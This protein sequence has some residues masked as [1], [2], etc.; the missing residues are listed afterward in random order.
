MAKEGLVADLL[1]RALRGSPEELKL[2]LSLASLQLTPGMRPLK[3]GMGNKLIVNALAEACGDPVSELTD[4]LTRVGDLGVLAESRLAARPRGAEVLLTLADVHAALI[5]LSTQA[6]EGSTAR[7]TE[8]LAELLRSSSPVEARYM[9]R[10]LL[11]KLRTGLGGRSLRAALGQAGAATVADPSEEL[12]ACEEAVVIAKAA[13]EEAAVAARAAEASGEK[14]LVDKAGVGL[15]KAVRAVAAAEKKLVAMRGKRRRDAVQRVNDVFNVQPC[16]HQLVNDLARQTVWELSGGAVAGIPLTPMTAAP[17]ASLDEVMARMGEA[18]PFLAEIKY[19][20]ERCQLHLLPEP[21]QAAPPLAA[22]A[23]EG[24]GEVEVEGEAEAAGEGVGGRVVLYSRSLDDMSVRFPDVTD[25]LPAALHGAS[26]CVLDAE[27]C[28]YDPVAE[29]VLP[30]QT[31]SSRSRKAPTAEETAATPVCL[32]VFDL[33]ELDG[34]SLL[35]VPLGERRALLTRHVQR[36]PGRLELAEGVEVHDAAGLEA[37]LMASVE[38]Q[39]EGLMCKALTGD[40]GGYDPGKRSLR[41]LKLKRDYIDSLGDSIDVAPIG[42]YYG[43]GKRAGTFGAYLL[44]CWDPSSQRWQPMGKLGSGFSDE[45]LAEWHSYFTEGE[46]RT[47]DASASE[48]LPDWMDVPGDG[49]PVGFAK[50]NVWL[51]PSTLWEVRAA[52]LSLSPTWGAA[53]GRVPGGGERGLA[54]RFPRFLRPR[55]DKALLDATTSEQLA[56]MFA[57]Q[58]EASAAAAFEASASA[59]EAA[60]SAAAQQA[61]EAHGGDV[62]SGVAPSASGGKFWRAEVTGCTLTVSWGKVGTKGQ[63]KVMEYGSEE[64]ARAQRE[65]QRAKKEKSKYV[66]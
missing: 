26:S 40:D 25:L 29:A 39:A 52:A 56:A 23:D 65:K 17:A 55:P 60:A 37:A 53:R 48:V 43:T 9:V 12:R 28:A 20:G 10:S 35:E 7:K 30:F 50:P 49:L 31:L 13:A 19:D 21:L 64:E 51:E 27:V 3:L 54:L 1:E 32:F 57:K 41:W 4:E 59:A 11:G 15:R 8:Q 46:G 36:V 2:A 16:Y 63:S 5:E 62:V 33:L 22:A 66:F 18:L 38:Q 44:G 58:P 34:R 45:D 61:A 14:K 6:G 47:V 42:G 24:E